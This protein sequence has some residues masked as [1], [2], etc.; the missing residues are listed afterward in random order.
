MKIKKDTEYQKSI[1][2]QSV[3]HK[4][5]KK[6]KNVFDLTLIN[7]ELNN[8]IKKKKYFESKRTKKIKKNIAFIPYD[9]N[10]YKYNIEMIKQI[11][12]YKP[13]RIYYSYNLTNMYKVL[14]KKP[15]N[16]EKYIHIYN[17][18]IFNTFLNKKLTDYTFFNFKLYNEDEAIL[19]IKHITNALEYLSKFN[20]G[21]I[22]YLN[23]DYIFRNSYKFYLIDFGCT[24]KINKE[25]ITSNYLYVS[26]NSYIKVISLWNDIESL[27]YIIIHEFTDDLVWSNIHDINNIYKL[28]YDFL[29]NNLEHQLTILFN[30]KK[31]NYSCYNIYTLIYQIL[32]L[33]T[34]KYKFDYNLIY[35]KISL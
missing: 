29:N 13:D 17:E 22:N 11:K 6:N 28:K 33:K 25:K 35:N 26:L 14:Y 12:D 30:R 10:N 34:T 7:D 9:I 19:C 23:K 8:I 20:I 31:N 2:Q 1:N 3:K 27:M 5:Y 18:L 15:K 32:L 4:V 21:I 16:L 24:T